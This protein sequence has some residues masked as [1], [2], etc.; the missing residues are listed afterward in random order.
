MPPIEE[1]EATTG[2]GQEEGGRRGDRANAGYL[3]RRTSSDI[4]A[5]TTIWQQPEALSAEHTDDEE[6]GPTTGAASGSS[7]Q[8]PQ[9]E[10]ESIANPESQ[11]LLSGRDERKSLKSRADID[12][13]KIDISGRRLFEQLDFYLIFGVM[14]LVS[15][16]GLLL[17]NNVGTITKTLWDFNHRD[18]PV[19]VAALNSKRSLSFDELKL[20]AKS[21]VQ[22]MQA[23][24]VSV[25]SLC[26]ASGESL[27]GYCPMCWS[28]KPLPQRTVF[29]SSS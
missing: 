20:S 1:L 15:G 4:G 7:R 26:N 6:D 13:S 12:P 9:D 11:G 16:A 25:I 5:R 23:R 22:Q 19:L 29:G 17:I 14:T 2:G 8:I 3:R 21:S 28:T 24:Q 18:N 10:E 27:L